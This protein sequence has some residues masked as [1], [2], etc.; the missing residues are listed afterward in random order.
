LIILSLLVGSFAFDMH[1]EA[2]ITSY[3]R[4]RV[5]AQY[6]ARAGVE[7][8]K[9]L[10]A[11]SA[12]VD[13]DEEAEEGREDLVLGAIQ[14]SRGVGVRGL[15]RQLGEGTFTLDLVAEEGRRN[16]NGLSDEDW[17]EILD[18]ANV[19]EERWDELIDCFYDWVDE[20]DE[21]HLNGAESDDPF[22]VERGYECKNAALDTVDEL[23]LIKGFDEDVVYGAPAE[24]EDEQPMHGI[25]QWLTVWGDSKVNVNAASREV[26]MTLPEIDEWTV[27][28]IIEGRK[29]ADGEGGT[30]D[31]G[32]ENVGEVEGSV[33]ALPEDLKGKI[34]TSGGTFIRVVSIGEV[35]GVRNGIWCVLH[36]E[37][38]E[39]TPVFWREEN[40]P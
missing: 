20:N 5:K 9:V 38:Q 28:D 1:I 19:P 32:Y 26:M 24:D 11:K 3:Y 10:L 15:Q 8:A 2:G 29:G 27:D 36:A 31:D 6:L 7:W 33:G 12:E 37:G 22:Y 23:L 30:R 34:S 13:E 35:Q 14:L 25:A 17:E 4:K 39:I 40:M 18:Q 21:H 16:I